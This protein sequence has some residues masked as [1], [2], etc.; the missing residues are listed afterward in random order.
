MCFLIL[1]GPIIYSINYLAK[2]TKQKSKIEKI[3]FIFAIS[4]LIIFI[5]E[6]VIAGDLEP[7]VSAEK[8][9]RWFAK[10]L[11]DGTLKVN[12][13]LK[14]RILDHDYIKE[15]DQQILEF[16]HKASF[17]FEV[18]A[19]DFH[20]VEEHYYWY[21]PEH[22]PKYIF[23]LETSE[24]VEILKK[25][26]DVLMYDIHIKINLKL[27]L[28]SSRFLGKYKRWHVCGFS[29][30]KSK[31]YKFKERWKRVFKKHKSTKNKEI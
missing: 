26:R 27:V 10:Y 17:K 30:T 23:V 5:L 20:K 3:I 28:L 4:L 21:F 31:P 14:K 1:L 22:P 16:E 9:A 18:K 25:L 6:L 19:D 2:K 7:N 15:F 24:I 13:K 11:C 8:T 29:I 12:D